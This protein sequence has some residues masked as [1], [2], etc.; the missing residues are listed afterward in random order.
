MP[1]TCHYR[2]GKL[3]ELTDAF[4][5]ELPPIHYI[6]RV[7]RLFYVWGHSYELRE[8]DTYEVME[9][10]AKKV[11]GRDDIW[12]ATNLEV[13]NYVQAFDS[14]VYSANKK[15]VYNPSALDV[16]LCWFGNDVLVPAGKTVD[17]PPFPY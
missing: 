13:Y 17:L 6:K 15:S 16:Y 3:M 1:A 4:L 12:Y 11:G 14:L 8:M 2:N 10:F 5:E 9:E 7:P